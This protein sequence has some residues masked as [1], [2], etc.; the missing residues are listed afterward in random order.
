MA[1][2]KMKYAFKIEEA[3][4]KWEEKSSGEKEFINTNFGKAVQSFVLWWDT[5]KAIEKKFN[6]DVM[7]IARVERWKHSIEAGRR[8]AKKYEEHGIKDL[9]DAYNSAYEGL[10]QAEWFELNDEVL[11]KWNYA[12]PCII[13]FKNLGKTKEEIMEMASLFCLADIGVMTGFNPKLEVFR[14]TRLLLKGDSH[15]C[16][17]V[18]D[19]GG[20]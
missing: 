19:H 10:V 13:H 1:E 11:H 17:R 20:R 14:Q 7:G 6:I 9:Y 5:L 18:E 12:C 3:K 2:E 8:L 4:K 16:Y 15:C